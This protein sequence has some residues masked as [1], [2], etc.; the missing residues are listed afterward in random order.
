MGPPPAVEA[1][2]RDE[3]AAALGAPVR[4]VRLLH[5]RDG[6]LVLRVDVADGAVVL[7]LTSPEA[8]RGDDERTTAVVA[9]VR[10]ARGAGAAVLA[11]Q[12]A[13]RPS[14]RVSVE[15]HVDGTPWRDVCG[16]T[17]EREAQA[18]HED[19]AAAVL[20]L[21]SLRLEGFGELDRAGRPAGLPL[22]AALHA[23]VDLRVPP[24]P[25]RATAHELLAREAAVF[26][27][28]DRRS[29]CTTTC[30]PP[31]CWSAGRRRA[32]ASPPCSTGRRPGPGRS[33]RTSPDW[34]S[35]TA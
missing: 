34:R 24:G 11:T 33:T 20:A 26:D 2:V 16:A 13:L 28:D 6:A 8:A 30:T 12:P 32:G 23:R 14:W 7:R 19:L 27:D 21:R 18:V 15:E 5:R 3:A 1:W 35:G 10:A 22:P 4:T 29:W 31:T 17:T 25:A 9:R